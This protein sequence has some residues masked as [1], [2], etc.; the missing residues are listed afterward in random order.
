MEWTGRVVLATEPYD[1]DSRTEQSLEVGA[2]PLPGG[3]GRSRKRPCERD[4]R[5][6]AEMSAAKAVLTAT[7]TSRAFTGPARAQLNGKGATTLVTGHGRS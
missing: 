2:L 7:S 3:V 4:A 1:T 5:Q 6:R